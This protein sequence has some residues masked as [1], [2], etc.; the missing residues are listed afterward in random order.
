MSA[1]IGALVAELSANTASFQQDMGKAVDILN[2]HAAEMN[3]TVAGIE[4]SISKIGDAFVAAVSI[5]AVAKIIKDQ[6]ELGD[7][8]SKTSEKV[9]ISVEKLSAYQYAAK[10]SNVSNE[11]LTSSLAKLGKAINEAATTPTSAAARAFQG[12]GVSVKDSS[13]NLRSLGSVFEDV[14]QRLSLV[15]KEDPARI[16]YEMALLG[17]SGYEMAPLLSS[18]K[19]LTN[20]AQRTG[21]V[22]TTDFAKASEKF[23]DDI[24]R[25]EL[26]TSRFAR[27]I[28]TLALPALNDLIERL[29]VAIGAQQGLSLDTLSK[30]RADL[31]R[32]YTQL[33]RA[34]LSENSARAVWLKN[35]IEEVDTK[36]IAA[37]KDLTRVQQE[38]A[39]IGKPGSLTLAPLGTGSEDEVKKLEARA[40]AIRAQISPMDALAQ[41]MAELEKL[42]PYLTFDTYFEALT[43]YQDEASDAIEKNTRDLD[44]QR[45]ALLAGIGDMDAL[46][47]DID[48]ISNLFTDP[49]TGKIMEQ[50]A[51]Q[52]YQIIDKMQTEAHNKIKGTISDFNDGTKTALQEITAAVKG[53][54]DQ[55]TNQIADMVMKGKGSF[56]DLADSIIRDLVR[57]W[58]QQNITRNLITSTGTAGPW[59]QGLA[60]LFGSGSGTSA[61][62]HALG[63]AVTAGAPYLVGEH[64]PELFVPDLGG[65]I[66]PNGQLAGGPNVTVQ[67]TV[68]AGVSQT[69]RAEMMALMPS[70]TDRAKQGVLAA[71][72]RGGRYAQAVGRKA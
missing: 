61:T 28:T 42:R 63:G 71:I 39:K 41:K 6:V 59:V 13:G 64:G 35:Q 69:V 15:K 12:L 1:S 2:S 67:M 68:N 48:R 53:W 31:A 58:V 17:K 5:G 54:G 57:I 16:A 50:Y 34:G 8:L 56:K 4:R 22:I 44:K 60:G 21:N 23:N 36:I 3:R 10:L 11:D 38:Q 26:G 46:Q 52:Y 65:R 51:E 32:Q 33:T 14:A 45:H 29:N 43:K 20:E 7:Q 9:G 66:I 40:A 55:F 37:N 49:A 70:I 47:E 25:L 30:Q 18:L 72:D 62:P 19:E 24:T 27:T